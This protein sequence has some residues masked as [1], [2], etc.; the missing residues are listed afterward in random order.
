MIFPHAIRSL[1]LATLSLLTMSCSPS[2]EPALV[3]SPELTTVQT[4][5][6]ADDE[7]GALDPSLYLSPGSSEENPFAHG[8]FK[9]VACSFDEAC[10]AKTTSDFGRHSID[11]TSLER[12][13][14]YYTVEVKFFYPDCAVNFDEALT[15]E[16][17]PNCSDPNDKNCVDQRAAMAPDVVEDLKKCGWFEKAKSAWLI[18]AESETDPRGCPGIKT[19]SELSLARQSNAATRLSDL[20][21]DQNTLEKMKVTKLTYDT[22][23]NTQFETSQSRQFVS[24]LFQF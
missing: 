9:S 4:T 6:K 13:K 20:F 3:T 17:Q 1:R 11:L 2:T 5:H 15:R 22:P 10:K 19:F 23:V 24:L 7:C 14:Q 21:E 16:W 8:A 18:T 12:M